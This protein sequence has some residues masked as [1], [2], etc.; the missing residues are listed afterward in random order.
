[1][2][3]FCVSHKNSI[4]KWHCVDSCFKSNTQFSSMFIVSHD[5]MSHC[6]C[7][8]PSISWFLLVHQPVASFSLLC[9]GNTSGN[10]DV[11]ALEVGSKV[12]LAFPTMYDDCLM[13]SRRR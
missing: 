5:G 6:F 4:H 9:V 2:F 13:M 3:R 10:M 7:K 12:S 1:M 11:A 8:C